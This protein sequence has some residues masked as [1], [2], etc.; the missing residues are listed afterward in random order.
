MV[1]PPDNP[2]SP[3]ARKIFLALNTSSLE[4]AM[5]L[6]DTTYHL[7]IGYKIGLRLILAGHGPTVSRYIRQRGFNNE[8]FYGA[9]LFAS[10]NAM[11]GATKDI[12]ALGVDYF[13]VCAMAGHTSVSFAASEKGDSKVLAETIPT[14]I[15]AEQYRSMFVA[16]FEGEGHVSTWKPD[17]LKAKLARVVVLLAKMAKWNGA[18]GIACSVPDLS[19]LMAD[20]ETAPLIKMVSGT[21][22]PGLQWYD[23]E[24]NGTPMTAFDVGGWEHT[25]LDIDCEG[26]DMQN[27]VAGIKAIMLAI[28]PY[29]PKP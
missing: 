3:A 24:C 11:K 8:V 6:V 19:I 13:D 14:M 10:P 1:M 23:P 22:L 9:N 20:T 16:P 25:Y 15:T 21:R 12:S 4:E 2:I 7:G 18:D 5:K 27:P 29:A 28:L 26:I 17:V